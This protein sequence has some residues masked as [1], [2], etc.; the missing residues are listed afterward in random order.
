MASLLVCLIAV[1]IALV[2]GQRPAHAQGT[3]TREEIQLC[4]L[5]LST[6]TIQKALVPIVHEM[7]RRSTTFRRQLL[8]LADAPGLV[9]TLTVTRFRTSDGVA[10]TTRF[11][12]EQS[13]LRRA[14]VEIGLVKLQRLVELIG[15]EFEHVIEQLDGVNLSQMAQGPG[16]TVSGDT[17][18]RSFETARARQIGLVVAGEFNDR[19]FTTTNLVIAR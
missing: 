17:R 15:H 8:R 16:V 11:A 18:V 13:V 4:A 12:R 2:P 6:L 9:V 10:A 19:F 5:P 7:C 14:D 3:E 1:A